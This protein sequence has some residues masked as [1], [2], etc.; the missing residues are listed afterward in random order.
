MGS[1]EGDSPGEVK[2][3]FLHKG[4]GLYAEFVNVWGRLIGKTY[5]IGEEHMKIYIKEGRNMTES[6]I[7][8]EFDLVIDWIEEGH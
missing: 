4:S 7:L 3:D 8:K 5:Q 2:E 6:G 1:T